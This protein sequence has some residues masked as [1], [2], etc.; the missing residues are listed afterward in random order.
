MSKIGVNAVVRIHDGKLEELKGVAEKCLACVREKDTGTLMY[1]W[2]LSSDGKT[3]MVRESYENSEAVLAH[4]GNLGP[5][6]GELMAVGAVQLEVFGEPSDQLREAIAAMQPNIYS[7]I[8][9][10]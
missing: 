3:C 6:L 9:I 7:T 5:L 1:D 2:Y 10:L 8:A 4:V